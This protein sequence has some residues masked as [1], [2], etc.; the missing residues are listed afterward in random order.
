MNVRLFRKEF[1]LWQR[2]P[3]QAIPFK[4][5]DREI[6][7]LMT[8]AIGYIFLG[9]GI[10]L[11]IQNYP[12][13]ILGAENFVQD[14]W[15]S[16]VF[17]IVFLLFIPACVYF[18]IWKY[19]IKDLM[20]DF[21]P[22]LKNWILGTFL[23]LFG[24]LLNSGHIHRLQEVFPLFED[25]WLRITVGV[26]LPLVIAGLPEELF[27][28]G[29]LQTRLEKKWNRITAILVSSLLF[30][31]WHLPSRFILSSGIEGQAGDFT[32]VILGTGVPVFLVSIFFGWHWS[33]YRNIVLLILT[34]WA[35]DILP[36]LTSMFGIR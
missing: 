32:S 8:Y 26:I 10:G 17:K 36:S 2:V 3:A 30:T 28:R 31:A 22:K 20:L 23:V 7:F 18:L 15:Y 14:F 27:F 1:W 33:R 21:R 11:L 13:P 19:S 24:F 35:I 29:Y 4:A 25:F 12:L 34:H 9:Y 16:I 6:V 5:L